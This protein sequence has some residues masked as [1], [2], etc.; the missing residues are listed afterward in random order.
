MTS[1]AFIRKLFGAAGLTLTLL[2]APF[3][4]AANITFGQVLGDLANVQSIKVPFTEVRHLSILTR[5]LT[6]H[7]ELIY[8]KPDFLEKRITA[9]VKQRFTLNGNRIT[10][11]D[12]Q[13]Q[14]RSISLNMAPPALSGIVD[15]YRAL[16]RG[17]RNAL[18]FNYWTTFRAQGRHWRLVLEPKARNLQNYLKNVTIDGDGARIETIDTRQANGDRSVMKMQPP[19]TD[20]K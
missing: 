19:A 16:L 15:A 3:A 7:G 10:L 4:H 6:L 17:D 13:G 2:I 9:P 20:G 14:T 1:G 5:A 11:V 12:A 8:R 18:E